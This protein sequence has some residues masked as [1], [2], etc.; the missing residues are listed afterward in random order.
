MF[1]CILRVLL[2]ATAVF[3]SVAWESPSDGLMPLPGTD[4]SPAEQPTNGNF[5]STFDDILNNLELIANVVEELQ[6]L[7]DVAKTELPE[8][9]ANFT[10]A[11][12]FDFAVGGLAYAGA[13]SFLEDNVRGSEVTDTSLFEEFLKVTHYTFGISAKEVDWTKQADPAAALAEILQVPKSD[14]LA[15]NVTDQLYSQ[16]WYL[17]VNHNDERLYLV[18]RGSTVGA[19]WLTDAVGL[20]IE[21]ETGGM[22]H[23]GFY[24][25]A[26]NLIR[27]AAPHIRSAVS[28]FPSYKLHV[29]GHSLGAG[30]C[31]ISALLLKEKYAEDILQGMSLEA[32]CVSTPP[33]LDPHT[34]KRI[35]SYTYTLFLQDDVVV[36]SSVHN[37]AALVYSSKVLGA[38][39]GAVFEALLK[40]YCSQFPS[41]FFCKQELTDQA[42]TMDPHYI[43]DVGTVGSYCKLEVPG[44]LYQIQRSKMGDFSMVASGSAGAE[45]MA[46]VIL[47]KGQQMVEDHF[48]QNIEHA[49]KVLAGTDL[50]NIGETPDSAGLSLRVTWTV[51]VIM[52]WEFYSIIQLDSKH[53]T[54]YSM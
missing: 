20:C 7:A 27:F 23:L 50:S 10:N 28:D 4:S 6:I 3:S 17:A 44:V 22:A 14:I 21:L 40:R 16:P 19:D 35:G 41:S 48:T 11:T 30:V 46:G 8:P 43:Q 38:T 54:A 52:L 2:A 5:S 33:S 42:L 49:L 31:S 24:R 37:V 9:L 15:F 36:R 53:G 18:M 51:A 12:L 39:T 32:N 26:E 1:A 34:A 47:L 45:R 13:S 29:T 25:S